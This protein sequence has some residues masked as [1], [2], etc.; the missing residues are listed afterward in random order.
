MWVL[1]TKLGSYAS[2]VYTLIC[3]GISLSQQLSLYLAAFLKFDWLYIYILTYTYV[4]MCVYT[5][6]HYKY[7]G[8]CVY[9]YMCIHELC[10]QRYYIYI[11]ITF[12]LHRCEYMY[13]FKSKYLSS[14]FAMTLNLG[15]TKYSLWISFSSNIWWRCCLWWSLPMHCWLT[16]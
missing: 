3:W 13:N 10:K 15:I 6:M 16:R 11:Y 7:T 12:L 9:T 5:C 8:L 2:S 4:C 1:G 14:L